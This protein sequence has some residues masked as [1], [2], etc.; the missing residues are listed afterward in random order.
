MAVNILLHKKSCYYRTLFE[1]GGCQ[2]KDESNT[3]KPSAQ[4]VT[5][6]RGRLGNWSYSSMR[7]AMKLVPTVARVLSDDA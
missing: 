3:Y 7:S 1:A 2:R 6:N 5:T 4:K